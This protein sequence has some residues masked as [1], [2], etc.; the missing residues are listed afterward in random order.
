[1]AAGTLVFVPPGA[2]QWVRNTGSDPLAFL[3]V[4]EPAW[5][6]QSEEILE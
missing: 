3:C 6:A 2:E 4:V 1:V 5:T